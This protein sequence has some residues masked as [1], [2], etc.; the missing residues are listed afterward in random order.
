MR[1]TVVLS[2]WEARVSELGPLYNSKTPPHTCPT[3]KQFWIWKNI[4]NSRWQNRLG[5]LGNLDGELS[6]F[7]V[8]VLVWVFSVW[9]PKG[10]SLLYHPKIK[11][12]RVGSLQN[13]WL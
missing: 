8:T 13:P 9:V 10:R 7:T 5:L 12:N 4:G 6:R 1:N 11:T 3:S 2:D